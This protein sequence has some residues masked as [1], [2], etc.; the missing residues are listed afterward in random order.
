MILVRVMGNSGDYNGDQETHKSP[1]WDAA[2]KL[3]RLVKTGWTDVDDLTGRAQAMMRCIKLLLYTYLEFTS[4]AFSS[5]QMEALP[6]RKEF[7]LR[8]HRNNVADALIRKLFLFNARSMQLNGSS[9]ICDDRLHVYRSRVQDSMKNWIPDGETLVFCVD[10]INGLADDFPQDFLRKK[11]IDSDEQLINGGSESRGLMYAVF[12]VLKKLTSTE[13]SWVCYVTGTALSVAKLQSEIDGI[14]VARGSMTPVSLKTLLSVHDMV[15]ILQYYFQFDEAAIDLLQ[16][17]LTPFVG[18]PQFFARGVFEPLFAKLPKNVDAQVLSSIMVDNWTWMNPEYLQ[19]QYLAKYRHFFGRNAPNLPSGARSA[20]ALLPIVLRAHLCGGVYSLP[21]ADVLESAVFTGILPMGADENSSALYDID[22][23]KEPIIQKA[24]G[25]FVQEKLVAENGVKTLLSIVAD[26]G[27]DKGKL[28]ELIFCFFVV[29]QVANA[30][31]QRG[32]K[33]LTLYSLITSLTEESHRDL[34]WLDAYGYLVECTNVVDMSV[35]KGDAQSFLRMFAKPDNTYDFK[36]I[37]VNIDQCAGADIAFLVRHK[38]TLMP[39]LVLVQAKNK[40]AGTLDESLLTLNPGC[41]CLTNDQ[42][43]WV[44]DAVY[45]GNVV[46]TKKPPMFEHMGYG[47]SVWKD[48]VDVCRKHPLLSQDCIRMSLNARP[49]S[50]KLLQCIQELRSGNHSGWSQLIRG[51]DK[52]R[53]I[54]MSLNQSPLIVLSMRTTLR[55]I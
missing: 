3:I 55:R 19:G 7:V 4:L 39:R 6:R 31:A 9:I 24:I 20:R 12:C 15:E 48:H 29:L 44:I 35:Q 1:P 53:K 43:I 27:G 25:D 22:L 33:A 49:V 32:G 47:S 42:R 36:T 26:I 18:R 23:K 14:S 34:Q 52:Q 16:S 11:I 45:N 38:T 17:K 28:A 46:A 8:L 30:N 51:K 21:T 37:L 10:E 41:Q 2:I 40:Q 54:T 50:R 13:S 5:I